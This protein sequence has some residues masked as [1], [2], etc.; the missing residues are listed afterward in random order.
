MYVLCVCVY[1]HM[2]VYVYKHY[3]VYALEYV[4]TSV[5]TCVFVCVLS[6]KCEG[7]KVMSLLFLNSS[8]LC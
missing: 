8:L 7:L 4:C 3:C 5:C 1:M 6:L 2:C